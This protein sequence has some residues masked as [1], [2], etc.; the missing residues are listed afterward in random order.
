MLMRA[1]DIP[2][3]GLMIAGSE[4]L[5]VEGWGLRMAEPAVEQLV[6]ADDCQ[7]EDSGSALGGWQ[8]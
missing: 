8:V 7:T 3:V 2:E 4:Q 5:V 1:M 6:A